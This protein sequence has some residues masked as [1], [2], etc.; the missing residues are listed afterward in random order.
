MNRDRTDRQIV[1][2]QKLEVAAVV[3]GQR[4][5]IVGFG[6]CRDA[7]DHQSQSVGNNRVARVLAQAA[8]DIE[9]QIGRTDIH[10]V[11]D[12]HAATRNQCHIVVRRREA[13]HG[14]PVNGQ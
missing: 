4:V 1:E 2:I 12:D 11:V 7:C 5:D 3:G 13:R 10:V 9:S 14:H 6:E 8:R